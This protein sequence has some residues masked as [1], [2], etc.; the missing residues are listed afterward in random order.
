MQTRLTPLLSA[1]PKP[2]SS[3]ITSVAML[4]ATDKE[5]NQIASYGGI[6]S[7]RLGGKSLQV[8]GSNPFIEFSSSP[9]SLHGTFAAILLCPP[10]S[11]TVNKTGTLLQNTELMLCTLALSLRRHELWQAAEIPNQPS[12][13]RDTKALLPDT[14]LL[15]NSHLQLHSFAWTRFATAL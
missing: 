4:A 5:M 10:S 3:P 9:W 14:G 13:S 11:S 8:K 12:V 6:L 15:H 2:M 1:P 7:V